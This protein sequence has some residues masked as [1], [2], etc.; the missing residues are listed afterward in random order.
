MAVVEVV[1]EREKPAANERLEIGRCRGNG[2]VQTGFAD[3]DRIMGCAGLCEN[4]LEKILGVELR[5]RA[6]CLL[7]AQGDFVVVVVGRDFSSCRN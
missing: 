4:L 6:V 1:V 5:V 7:F 3:A 2:R